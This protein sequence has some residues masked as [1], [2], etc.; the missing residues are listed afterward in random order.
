MHVSLSFLAKAAV[1]GA[2]LA[3]FLKIP[4]AVGAVRR[5][6]AL[7]YSKIFH[8]EI[9]TRLRLLS[10]N[11]AMRRGDQ[12]QIVE[13]LIDFCTACRFL[14]CELSEVQPNQIH[15]S[16][17]VLVKGRVADL[18]VVRTLARSRPFDGRAIA[19]DTEQKVSENSVWSALLGK[20]DGSH[21]WAKPYNCFVCNNLSKHPEEF[22]CPRPKWQSHYKS[23]LA[24]PLHY[25]DAEDHTKFDTLGFL[26]FDSTKEGVFTGLPDIFEY[27]TD[28]AVYHDMLADNTIFHFGA[29]AAGSLTMT[30]RPPYE[31]GMMIE[32]VGDGK[33]Q[34]KR[35]FLEQSDQGISEE[36]RAG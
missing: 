22:C 18:D 25:P 8:T 29:A 15:C 10:A 3:R 28:W 21:N 33:S 24:F 34:A 13:E 4:G 1:S 14:M 36:R 35:A 6:G 9:V 32:G 30:L 26:A 11:L 20:T 23:T 17:K 16:I 31:S 7:G 2:R 19:T 12:R 27:K 5:R